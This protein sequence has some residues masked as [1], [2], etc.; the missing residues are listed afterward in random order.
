MRYRVEPW[1]LAGVVALLCACAGGAGTPSVDVA[2]VPDVQGPPPVD[3]VYADVPAPADAPDADAGDARPDVPTDAA[4]D[5]P[6]DPG[7]VDYG[8]DP[9]GEVVLGPVGHAGG[10]GSGGVLSGGGL[11]VRASLGSVRGRFVVPQ[12]GTGAGGNE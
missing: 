11:R 7:K 1:S 8:A 2:D 10:W 4:I 6:A 9:G 5:L 12:A 3:V